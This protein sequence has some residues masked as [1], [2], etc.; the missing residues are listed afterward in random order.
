M[1]TIT[2]VQRAGFFTQM[3]QRPC[4]TCKGRGVTCAGKAGCGTCSGRGTWS[5][6][7]R[8]ELELPPGVQTGYSKRFAGLGEQPVKDDDQPGDLVMEVMVQPDRVFMRHGDDLVMNA[9]VTFAEAV[10]GSVVQ[11]PALDGNGYA[12]DTAEFGVLKP[13]EMYRCPGK[14]MPRANGNG[15]GDLLMSFKISYPSGKLSPD[16]R[17]FL[18]NAFKQCG[19]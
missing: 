4:D 12:V 17:D 18:A 2:H 9:K 5:E 6:E 15:H 1:G 10:V 11:V 7:H 14:G 13:G 19:I 16:T 3:S 8:L